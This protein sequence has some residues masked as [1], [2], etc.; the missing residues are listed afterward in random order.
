LTEKVVARRYA[1]ALFS[2]GE[3]DGIEK[4]KAYGEDLDRFVEILSASPE[5]MQIFR[6]PIFSV[7]D[8]KRV[9]DKLLEK[10][11]PQQITRNFIY[12]LADKGRLSLVPDV[13][14]YYEAM[15]DTAQ[16]VLR[17][18]L[19]TAKD[20]A[21][22]RQKDIKA[23]LE[24]QTGKKLVLEYSVDPDILG[25]VVLKVGDRV[26]D[27]SLRAQLEIIKENIKRGE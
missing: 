9:V 27:A 5:L 18:R 3:K 6:N 16:G 23:K 25:G 4:L 20:L 1:R 22:G 21:E 24:E 14:D 2:A 15:L 13:S 10:L 19:I 12:L 17:G 8:K 7:E 11:S 26:L